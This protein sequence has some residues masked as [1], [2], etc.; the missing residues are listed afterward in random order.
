MDAAE[1]SNNSSQPL[2]NGEGDIQ[3]VTGVKDFLQKFKLES[4]KLW[5]LAAPAILTFLFRYS[6]GAVTQI[7][8]G[9]VGTLALAAFSIENSVIAGF[10]FG[11]M[12]GMASA[13]ET[14][15][16]QAYGAGQIEMLG[17]YLQR[18]WIILTST[19]LLLLPLYIFATP[20]LKLIGQTAEISE[21]AGTF[22]LYMIPQLFAYAVNFPITRFLQAQRKI[23]VIAGITG[24]ALVLHT[25]FS[26][27]F[28]MKLD[29]GMAGAAAVL[30]F[31]WVFIMAAQLSY[32]LFGG[33]GPTWSGFSSRAFQDI[34]AFV[35]LSL[36]S[37][38]MMC[39]EVWYFMVLILF[40]GYLKNAE[41]SLDALSICMN[42]LGWT[43]MMAMGC[44]AATSVRISN[45]LGAA[46]P[47]AAKLAHSRSGQN[48]EDDWA[49]RARA[50][51]WASAKTAMD[52]QQQ[53]SPFS[54]GMRM[55]LQTRLPDQ[56]SRVA[57]L[58]H[59]E[60]KPGSVGDFQLSLLRLPVP[61]S[62]SQRWIF[63]R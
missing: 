17:V 27:V 25:L 50:R 26:W 23:N 60:T 63:G 57:D 1:T 62:S 30:N 49:A 6:L 7:F 2:L 52:N 9:Q 13:L 35:R 15:C 42:I 31:S 39:L 56:G 10:C 47:R 8:L 14:L 33:C 44:S 53:Q 46:H 21:A 51:V 3:P 22:A 28:V 4:D 45:E 24:V 29:W 38:V 12:L 20:L 32:V 40:A 11:I 43:V 54:R 16:G 5:A 59:L 55:E 18:S 61:S 36:A 58:Q 19:A 37:A 34:W 41:V 48:N